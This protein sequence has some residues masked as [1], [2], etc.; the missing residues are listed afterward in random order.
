MDAWDRQE[1]SEAEFW[2]ERRDAKLGS[3]FPF[4][5]TL[6]LLACDD[7]GAV[8][9]FCLC[10]VGSSQGELIGRVAEVG[11]VRSRR[12]AGTGYALLLSG[13]HELRDRG[14]ARIVLDVDAENVTT[15]LRLYA[16]AAMTPKPAF[17]VWEK[18]P[19]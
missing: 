3:A 11:C 12:G 8:I 19:V 1:S 6:W 2:R 10:E 13:F 14:V 18:A 9:G 15:A 7:V 17:T 16:K 4:D 5:A